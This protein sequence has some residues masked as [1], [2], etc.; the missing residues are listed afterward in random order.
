VA[1]IAIR[2]PSCT[3]AGIPAFHQIGLAVLARIPAKNITWRYDNRRLFDF[4]S[5]AF[6]DNDV[7]L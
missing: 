3:R 7:G 6:D 5:T 4:S 1:G 2:A